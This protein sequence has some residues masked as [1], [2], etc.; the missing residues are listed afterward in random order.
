MKIFNETPFVVGHIQS[1]LEP[2]QPFMALIV[3][4]TFA[5]DTRGVCEVLPAN[6][7]PKLEKPQRFEDAHGNSHKTD[8]DLIAFKARTDCLFVGSAFAPQ[9]KPVTSLNVGMAVGPMTKRLSVYGDRD[10]VRLEDGAATLTDP[11]PFVEMPIREEYAHGGPKSVHNRHGIGFARLGDKPGDRVKAANIMNVGQG[12]IAWNKDVPS[13]GLGALPG[14]L[15]PRRDLAGTFDSDWLYRRRPLPPR[16]FNIEFFNAARP[17]QQ[18]EGY[19]RGDERIHLENL[20]PDIELLHILLPG[21]GV[22]CFVHRAMDPIGEAG[23]EFAEVATNLDTCLVDGT[24][25]T[26]TLTWRGTLEIMSE[27][28]ERV[29]HILVAVEP[30]D[31]PLEIESYHA[32]LH[33]RIMERQPRVADEADAAA[34]REKVEAL[35]RRGVE[36]AIKTLRAGGAPD[37]LIAKVEKQT[38][39]DAVMKILTDHVEEVAKDLPPPPE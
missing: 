14:N 6:R 26:V 8:T 10:W 35:N 17:D 12:A 21:I 28:H 24:A 32:V 27:K 5:F 38:S 31:A 25:G 1:K 4:G 7:Q 3:K 13:A 11:A 30:V 39:V 37:A 20:H 16:D 9:G 34:A 33:T 15:K 19:L 22:R 29:R 36:Q 2:G 23:F 18:I